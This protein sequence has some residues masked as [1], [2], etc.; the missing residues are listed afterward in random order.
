MKKAILYINQFF[1]GIGGEEKADFKPTILEKLSG[2]GTLIQDG[3]EN[4]EISHTLVCGDNFMNSHR[5]ET[6]KFIDDF[7]KD[8]DFDIFLAGPAFQSG[9]YGMNCGA[10][11]KYVNEN[12]HVPT[13]TSMHSENPGLD[14][15]RS[16]T[17]MYIMKGSKSASKMWKDVSYMINIANK[18]LVGKEIL[19]ADAEGYFGHGIRKECFVKQTSTDR[20]FDMLL[21]KI[22][23]KPYETEY[24]IEI[25]ENVKPAAA[26]EDIKTSKLAIITTGG[27]VPVGNPDHLPS[28]TASVW[29]TYNIDKLKSLLPNEFYSIHGGFSTD[30]VNKDPEVLIPLAT[31]KELHSKGAFGHLE[32]YIYTTTGNL[33]ALKDARRMGNEIATELNARDVTA[34]ILVST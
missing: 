23:G 3:L 9:R 26:V 21:K 5:K 2:P 4:A 33:T 27:L 19:W 30:N 32:P 34:A 18:I 12:Y 6:F 24:K 29:K 11:C 16:F 25:H 8:K 15:Y 13:I 10:V 31:I 17:G 14:T 22:A 28:G 20:A 1:A 7:L